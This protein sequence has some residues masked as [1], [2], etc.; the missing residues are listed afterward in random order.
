[1][2]KVRNEEFDRLNCPIFKSIEEIGDGWTLLIIRECY[3]GFKRFEDLRENLGISKSVLSVRIKGLLEKELLVK[4]EYQVPQQ[5]P[6][7]E[8]RLTQKGKDLS[9]IIMALVEWGNEYLVDLN[10][11]R[12]RLEE[13]ESRRPVRLAV[14][15]G[16]G[17][18]IDKTRVRPGFYMKSTFPED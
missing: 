5:R 18:E 1:M 9:L 13:K 7:Y 17:K 10:G 15:D 8:Y 6:R 16:E 3:L 2:E 12:L 14:L 11:D 4:C